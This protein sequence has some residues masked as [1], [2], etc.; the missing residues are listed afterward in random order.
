MVS[1]TRA[2]IAACFLAPF[3]A[4]AGDLRPSSPRIVVEAEVV[5]PGPPVPAPGDSYV[6]SIT[7]YRVL[8][9]LKGRYRHDFLLVGHD[10]FA[11]V[12]PNLAPGVRHR[13]E[14]TVSFPAQASQLNPFATEA[15]RIGIYY[16]KSFKPL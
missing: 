10:P 2:L 7:R 11:K 3:L 4:A 12:Q 16:C 5:E 1:T 9:V 6:I 8:K 15:L 14:L 13:L